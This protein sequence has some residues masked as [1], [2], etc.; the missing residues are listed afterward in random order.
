MV[1]YTHKQRHY[2]PEM[3]LTSAGFSY[4]AAT[5]QSSVADDSVIR[6]ITIDRML[7]LRVNG[8]VAAEPG[9]NKLAQ[10]RSVLDGLREE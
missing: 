2:L 6:A 3:R 7:G 10:F 4:E 5:S 8:I 9:I 1:I